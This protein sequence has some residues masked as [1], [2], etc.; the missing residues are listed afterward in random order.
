MEQLLRCHPEERPAHLERPLN[1]VNLNINELISTSDERPPFLKRHFSGAK[2]V[3]SQEGFQC[4]FKQPVGMTLFGG[5]RLEER[6]D[7]LSDVLDHIL[8]EL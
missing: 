5:V 1:N 7:V 3:A 6:Q 4:T 8:G 2:G